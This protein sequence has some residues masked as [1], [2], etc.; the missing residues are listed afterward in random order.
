[1]GG[2]HSLECN[3]I[4]R[5]I[6]M[7]CITRDIWLSA[8]HLPGKCNTAAD[9]ASRIFHDH[10]EWKLD[11]N[12]FVSITQVLGA[13]SIDLFASRLNFQTKPYIAWHPDPGAFAIDA[14][15]VD[16]GKHHFYAFPPFNLIDRVLQKV[17]SD[18][19][20]GILI[21]PQWTTQ[22]WFPVLMRLLVQEPLILPRG[23]KVLQLPYN[24]SAIHP[25]HHKLTLM[26]CKLSGCL[27]KVKD[28]QSKLLT[29]SCHHGENQQ[30]N[31][32]GHTL[33]DG[34]SFQLNGLVIPCNRL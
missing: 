24:P 18:Q 15:S 21:V 19:A 33:R 16:W 26:A 28:F 7:W 25:L 31:S 4:A 20:S 34:I 14:F 10:T 11:S 2:T 8:A 6:W 32:T 27:Y 30:R 22:P 9:K 1:M 3:H 12:I 13:P 5:T 29:L 17:E 23:K